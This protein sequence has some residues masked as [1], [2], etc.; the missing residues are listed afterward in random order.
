MDGGRRD[1]VRLIV[2]AGAA[3]ALGGCGDD[4][5][6]SCTDFGGKASNITGNHGHSLTVPAADFS[7]GTDHTYSI[8]GTSVHDHE[9]TLTAAQLSDIAAGMS[10]QVLSTESAVPSV[11]SHTVTV[12]CASG[13]GGSGG[14]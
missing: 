14:Y 1:F 5:K 10:V 4:G 9:I 2:V 7:S 11:H 12:T 6:V 8:M 13:G 3:T